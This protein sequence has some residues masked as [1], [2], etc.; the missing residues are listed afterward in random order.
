MPKDKE[1]EKFFKEMQEYQNK[2]NKVIN[3]YKN[4]RKK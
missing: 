4:R 2:F 1:Q 3:F